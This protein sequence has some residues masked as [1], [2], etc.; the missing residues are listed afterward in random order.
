MKAQ[1]TNTDTVPKTTSR[2]F[3]IWQMTGKF[4]A[5][6]GASNAGL[7]DRL[8]QDLPNGTA[9]PTF[10]MTNAF[11]ISPLNLQWN[12][13]RWIFYAHYGGFSNAPSTAD[14]TMTITS[15]EI[16]YGVGYAVINTSRFRLYPML[17]NYASV[18]ILN[19]KKNGSSL[20]TLL[21]TFEQNSVSIA[22]FGGLLELAIGADYSFP[23]EY[24]DVYIMAKVGYN[25]EAG[26][27]WGQEL[28][29][30]PLAGTDP[31]WLSRRG[32]FFQLGIGLGTERR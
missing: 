20:T 26:A 19:L 13:N 22:R 29:G 23:L 21:Q 1:E 16:L 31:N 17:G 18:D 27:L 28:L 10:T 32:V 8:N 6:G 9:K 14:Y 25:L 24:G 4:Q 3:W 30:R 12:H 7:N 2:P 5:F 15:Q 11:Y